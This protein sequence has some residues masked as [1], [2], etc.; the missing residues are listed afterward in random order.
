[1]KKF[2]C[3]LLVLIF[4]M[5]PASAGMVLEGNVSYTEETAREEAFSGVEQKISMEQ[6]KDKIQDKNYRENKDSF[7]SEKTFSDRIVQYF[8]IGAIK[9][10]AVTYLEKPGPNIALRPIFTQSPGVPVVTQFLFAPN[11][12]SSSSTLSG[13]WSVK[14]CPAALLSLSGAITYTSFSLLNASVRAL[15]PLATIPSS[16][17]IRIFILFSY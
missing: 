16:L 2:L 14:E 13:V 17:D 9:A 6:F 15:I 10:Y 12:G 8:K 5:L 1:M 7:K 3:S 11:F 4:V